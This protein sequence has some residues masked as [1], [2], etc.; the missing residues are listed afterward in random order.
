MR[1]LIN[2]K[3][4]V[5]ETP[6]RV[7]LSPLGNNVYDVTPVPGQTIQEGTPLGDE[8]MNELDEKGWEALQIAKLN[9][10]L[11]RQ[12]NDHIHEIEGEKIRVT[13]TNSQQ[14]PFNNSAKSVKLSE[15]KRS[16]DYSVLTEV[17]SADG[18]GVGDIRVTGRLLNGFTI[19]Y[20]GAAKS[21]TIDCWI[22]GGY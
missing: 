21:V 7:R 1:D 10:I 19:S 20:S 15:T 11:L 14:Y 12:H 9:A 6:N 13:L 16:L 8:N 4:H 17:V 18:G 3:N 22:Q 5:V 2:F